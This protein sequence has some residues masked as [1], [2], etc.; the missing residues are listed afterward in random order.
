MPLL[1]VTPVSGQAVQPTISI[2]SA[3]GNL[4]AR[5]FPVGSIADGDTAEVTWMPPFG[6][7]AVSSTPTTLGLGD[8]VSADTKAPQ[9]TIPDSAT[10]ST[11]V[12]PTH[13]RQD[14][15]PTAAA[16]ITRI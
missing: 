1:H 12:A 3:E 16:F 15:A 5:V 13:T 8:F 6:S 7:A 2:Y 11:L 9:Q 14:A 10:A 4:L